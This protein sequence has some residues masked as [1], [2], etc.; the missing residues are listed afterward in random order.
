VPLLLHCHLP[1]WHLL[2]HT[3]LLLHCHLRLAAHASLLLLLLLGLSY[4]HHAARV[5]WHSLRGKLHTQQ[6]L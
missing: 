5:G 6:Q 1:H 3:T 4:R 2:I